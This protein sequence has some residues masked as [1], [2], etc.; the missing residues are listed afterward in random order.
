MA[1]RSKSKKQLREEQAD[2]SNKSASSSS[3]AHVA[4]AS[5]GSAGFVK[6]RE[7]ASLESWEER[8][9]TKAEEDQS[10]HLHDPLLGMGPSKHKWEEVEYNRSQGKVISVDIGGDGSNTY[11]YTVPSD[12]VG[13]GALLNHFIGISARTLRPDAITIKIKADS[14]KCTNCNSAMRDTSAYFSLLSAPYN[15]VNFWFL[16]R[17]AS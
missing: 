1:E 12:L 14:P 10:R 9:L 16:I 17:I 11:S 2:A 6:R 7:S 5:G 4:V 8:N 13:H 15:G 3:T